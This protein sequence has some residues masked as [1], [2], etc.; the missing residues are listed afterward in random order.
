MKARM[1][2]WVAGV[3]GLPAVSGA[4]FLS[5]DFSGD[6]V[7]SRPTSVTIVSPA[8]NTGT[9]DTAG[10][11]GVVTVGTS[12]IGGGNAMRLYDRNDPTAVHVRQLLTTGTSSGIF[13]FNFTLGTYGGSQPS[14]D[15]FANNGNTFLRVSVGSNTVNATSS[16]DG[17]T[18]QRIV[19]SRIGTGSTGNLFASNNTSGSLTD[20]TLTTFIETANNLVVIIFNRTTTAINYTKS[21]SQSVAAGSYDV[22]FNGTLVADN[23]AMRTGTSNVAG[24]SMGSGGGQVGM[25]WIVDNL[26]VTA[27]PEPATLGLLTVGGLLLGTRLSRSTKV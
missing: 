12:V 15:S 24:I 9:G 19:F 16:T 25:D 13:S 1:A 10:D 17:N 8:S 26:S 18:F 27:I 14:S 23:F 22:W 4:A 3:L 2:M 20:T 5:N 6:T 7:G 11:I 21:G